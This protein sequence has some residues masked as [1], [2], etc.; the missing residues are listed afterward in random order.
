M[1]TMLAMVISCQYELMCSQENCNGAGNDTIQSK[2][3]KFV[4]VAC[5]NGM[6]EA[7]R[8]RCRTKRE[9]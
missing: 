6:K 1:Q 9:V 7:G 2:T 8:G 5:P 4:F 3:K